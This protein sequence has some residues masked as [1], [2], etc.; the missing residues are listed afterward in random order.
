MCTA[1]LITFGC[2]T[3][4]YVTPDSHGGMVQL[5]EK[6]PGIWPKLASR[7]KWEQAICSPLLQGLALEVFEASLALNDVLQEH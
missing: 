7:Q 1:R 2:E 4:R 6:L 3:V 5:I